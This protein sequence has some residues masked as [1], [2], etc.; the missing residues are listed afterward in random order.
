MK[1]FRLD[2]IEFRPYIF[3]KEFVYEIVKWEKNEN[4][5]LEQKFRDDGYVDSFGGDFLEKD[6]HSICKSYFTREEFCFNIARLRVNLKEPDVS[7]QSIGARLLDLEYKE[8]KNFWV[9][10]NHANNKLNRKY[11]IK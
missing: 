4:F 9:V 3:K 8:Q 1:P 10:Y 2:N 6:Y 5:G 7:L 11:K